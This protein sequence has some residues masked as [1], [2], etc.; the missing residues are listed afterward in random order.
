MNSVQL[1]GRLTREVDLKFTQN[2]TAM[3]TF[4]LAIDRRFTNQQGERET[5]FIRCVVWRKAAENLANFTRKGSLIGV[6]GRIQTRTYDN[7]QGQRQYITEVV[8][9]NFDFLEP[10][11]VTEQ[12]PKGESSHHHYANDSAGYGSSPTYGQSSGSNYSQQNTQQPAF[13]PGSPSY[14]TNYKQNPF[15]NEDMEPVDVSEDDLPF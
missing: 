6:E 13:N 8:V 3:G 12:R 10:K 15:A 5:D 14:Q 1:I 4:T 7:P 9:E 11:S 2:G